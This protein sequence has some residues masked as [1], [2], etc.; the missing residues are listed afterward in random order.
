MMR[1][2]FNYNV[3]N[4][5]YNFNFVV[6]GVSTVLNP[7]NNSIIFLNKPNLDLLENLK[8][9]KESVIFLK[10]T[11]T[12]KELEYQNIVKYVDNPRLEFAKFL[13][14]LLK[15]I[16]K[17]KTFKFNHLGYYHGENITIGENVLIEPFVRLGNNIK[18]GN[19][20]IIKSGVIIED[21]V[22]IGENCYIRE[23][24]I[25]GGEDFGIE[26]DIDGSTVRIPHF[27]GVR[28][29]NN[30]EIGA[31]STVCSGTIEETIVEDYVKVDYSVNVGHNTRIGRGTLICSGALIG[32]SSTLGN[33]VFIGMNASIKS[34]M[35]IGNNAVI[36][37]G[38]IICNY[39]NDGEIFTNEM[40]D[41]L[42][43]IKIIRNLKQKIL[44]RRIK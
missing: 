22:I 40:A 43:N 37:M 29:G 42:E 8:E 32:G 26:T 14:F 12:V 41:K 3:N 23:N 7:K 19:N 35:I 33:N 28:I 11:L 9:I 18:I 17:N 38:S 25:I 27:G 13:N 5:D 15:S 20:T 34:K 16:K 6:K 39:I 44:K 4:I 24:S 30:V 36:G 10:N 2:I 21:N 1:E 31:G